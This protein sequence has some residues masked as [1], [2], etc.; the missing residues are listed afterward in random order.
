MEAS[1]GQ[2]AEGDKPPKKVTDVPC[3]EKS[4]GTTSTGSSLIR[5]A[6]GLGQDTFKICKEYLRPLK[7]FLRK[8]HLPRDLPQKKKLKYMKQSLLVLGDHINTFL[9][10]YCRTWEIKHWRKMLW[11]FVSLFSEL[12]AKQLRRLY[13]YT[14]S[15]QTAKFLVRRSGKLLPGPA[16]GWLVAFCPLDAPESSLLAD[17][18]DSLPKLCSAWG[19][20]SNISGMKERLSKMQAP[21]P[22]ASLLGEPTS[23]AQGG[24]GSLR[25]LP[26]KTKLRRKRIEEAPETPETCA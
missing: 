20:H 6:K 25:K 10:H 11:R 1:D 21:G 9:Q 8:L 13:K 12:E 7:K 22:E 26:Q 23:G 4:S 18:E 16:E 15:N 14:K 24:P 5:H 2:G 17:Q 19:L 3:L